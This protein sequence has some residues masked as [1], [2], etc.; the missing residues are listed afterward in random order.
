M[1]TIAHCAS[2]DEA[3]FLK[4]LLEG[5]GLTAYIPDE[6][7]AQNLVPLLLSSGVK[8]QV[9]DDD[10]EAARAVLAQNPAG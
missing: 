6:F 10:A 3:Q 1:V 8:V 2:V 4:S 9:E 7:T 5:N